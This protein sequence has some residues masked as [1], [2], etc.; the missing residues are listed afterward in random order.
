MEKEFTKQAARVLEL[1]KNLAKK[2]RHPYVGTEHLL[3]ALRQEFT[4]VAG[5]VLAMN[6]VKEEEIE[7]R[8]KRIEKQ[9]K[10]ELDEQQIC[11]VKE[12]VRNGLLIITGGP[13][14]GKTTTIN[15]IIRYFEMEGMDI[16]L[17][18]PTGRAAKRMAVIAGNIIVRQRGTAIHAGNNVGMGTDHTLYALIDGKVKFEH[19]TKD[20]KQ[21]S[22]YA[23]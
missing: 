19:K 13:G 6:H 3:L 16:F 1:A 5:Q 22:V 9:T 17:G 11:A 20:K 4:G 15:T 10:I 18:A 7:K 14:T 12:A 2:F 23:D 8:I 21:V